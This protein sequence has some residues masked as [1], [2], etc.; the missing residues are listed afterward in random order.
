MHA[1]IIASFFT[2]YHNSDRSSM[3]IETF[4]PA[5]YDVPNPTFGFSRGPSLTGGVFTRQ[6]SYTGEVVTNKQ[7]SF[8]NAEKYQAPKI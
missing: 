1:I 7:N 2:F 5:T 3:V 6:G 8:T 4:D